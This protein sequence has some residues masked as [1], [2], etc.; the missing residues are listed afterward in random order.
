VIASESVFSSTFDFDKASSSRIA[1]PFF[2][3]MSSSLSGLLHPSQYDNQSGNTIGL[4]DLSIL[5][6]TVADLFH[7]LED[8]IAQPGIPI[9][10]SSF[11]I[12]DRNLQ[13]NASTTD[14][15]DPLTGVKKG[16]SS[17]QNSFSASM[18]GDELLGRNQEASLLSTNSQ[19]TAV[20]LASEWQVISANPSL[21]RYYSRSVDVDRNNGA[22][23]L[24]KQGY[25][26]VGL[27]RHSSELLAY[28]LLTKD[29]GLIDTSIKVLEYSFARQ[30]PDGS[31]QTTAKSLTSGISAQD[32]AFFFHD[33]GH[34]LQLAKNSDWFQNAAETANLRSRLN[35]L[36]TP[37][38]KSLTWL[39]QQQ[40]VLQSIDKSGTNRLFIDANAYYLTGKAIGRSDAV[41]AGTNFVRTALQQ[42]SS[43]G[44]FLERGG[45]DSSYN[46]VSLRHAIVLYTNLGSDAGSLRQ[47]LWKAI[48]KGINW[49]LT[50]IAPSGEVLT[51]GNTRILPSGEQYALTGTV[52]KVDYK[53]VVLALD[54][55]AKLTGNAIVQ[56]AANRVRNYRG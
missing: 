39:T 16:D 44:F 14:L 11:A 13:V 37:I 32:G 18:G 29:L 6:S 50:R 36:S 2:D 53:E 30:Q 26:S 28:G 1:S 7:S 9:N 24:N 47:D 49:Q 10:V 12:A 20:P 34:S 25:V 38:G 23:G 5:T 45:Y 55:Y 27:Q 41:T 22:V 48:E 51:Q 17:F 43:E 52:K 3:A 46:A 21:M 54:Y 15:T 40:P 31:F 4:N 33:V 56:D 19:A 8:E 35:K 42:Q